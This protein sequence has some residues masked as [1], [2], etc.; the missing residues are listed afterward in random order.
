MDGHSVSVLSYRSFRPQGKVRRRVQDLRI[1]SASRADFP[2][3]GHRLDLSHNESARMAVDSL[4]SRGLKE[5]HQVLRAEGEVDFLSQPEKMYIMENGRA[6][7]AGSSRTLLKGCLERTRNS[8]EIQP[9]L[10][11]VFNAAGS[12]T[13]G[14]QVESSLPDSQGDTLCPAPSTD[15]DPPASEDQSCQRGGLC[16]NDSLENEIFNRFL[17]ET[18]SR[19]FV[20]QMCPVVS[21]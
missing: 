1:S 9:F 14:D 15:S 5:Y 16:T 13:S 12:S 3:G 4:L 11:L 20:S 10:F 21:R 8:L 7:S 2:A 19:V 17:D 6:G 18:Y